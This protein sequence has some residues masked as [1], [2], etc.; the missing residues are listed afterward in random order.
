MKILI[1]KT[2][3]KEMIYIFLLNHKG[4][5][6]WVDHNLLED[7]NYKYENLYYICDAFGTMNAS[8]RAEEEEYRTARNKKDLS[9][10]LTKLNRKSSEDCWNKNGGSTKEQWF[11]IKKKYKCEKCEFSSQYFVIFF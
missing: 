5:E 8:E 11:N 4:Y 1:L 6:I 10:F 9:N 2:G 3:K 7:I